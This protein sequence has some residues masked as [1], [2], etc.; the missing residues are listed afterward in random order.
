M[1]LVIYGGNFQL[2]F[3]ALFWVRVQGHCLNIFLVR[4]NEYGNYFVFGAHFWSYLYS[5]K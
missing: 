3:A 5:A 2:K 1:Q 4:F